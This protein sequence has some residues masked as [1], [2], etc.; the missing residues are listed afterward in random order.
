M[1]G[2]GALSAMQVVARLIGKFGSQRVTWVGCL[3]T[4][5]SLAC[6]PFAGNVIQLAAALFVFGMVSGGM[7]VAMNA[8][9][10]AVERHAGR[11]I[12]ASLHALWSIG[13][14]CGAAIGGA[15]AHAG[16]NIAAHFTIMA[17]V[18]GVVAAVV[19]RHLTNDDV[20]SPDGQSSV[21][22]GTMLHA[23]VIMVLAAICLLA[24]VMEGAIAEWSALY[25]SSALHSDAGLASMGLAAFSIAMAIGR[26]FGDRV[27]EKYTDVNVLIAGGITTQIAV[28]IATIPQHPITALLGFFLAG[29]GLSV[30]VPITFRLAGQSDPQKAGV[31]IARVARAGYL[32]LLLGPPLLGFIAQAWGLR[33]SLMFLSVL[34]F[35]T[36]LLA[37]ALREARVRA[38]AG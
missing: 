13:S 16:W 18:I 34:A 14:M 19:S 12:M 9:A 5:I 22:T 37:R 8:N 33:S 10:V 7:D 23:R 4:A 17:T 26:L 28:L 36:F 30:Q 31:A 38:E 35:F 29:F 24:F 25:M 32:G 11:P 20:S 6:I 2:L 1:M 27:I 15:F 21:G 3:L